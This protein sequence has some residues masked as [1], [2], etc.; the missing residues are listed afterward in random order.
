MTS[1]KE[2]RE[3]AGYSQSELAEMVGL[4]QATICRIENGQ[5]R[6]YVDQLKLIAEALG[7]SAPLLL[8]RAA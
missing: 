1:I 6:L 4:N 7:V 2:A 3:K 5:Q 8:K